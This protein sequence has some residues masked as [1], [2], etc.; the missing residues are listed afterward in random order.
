MHSFT[1]NCEIFSNDEKVTAVVPVISIEVTCLEAM[2]ALSFSTLLV[3]VFDENN[4]KVSTMVNGWQY[5]RWMSIWVY[6][7]YLVQSLLKDA[8]A[9]FSV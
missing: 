7:N 9:I 1:I 8:K 6:I 5:F 3:K 4:K 2:L